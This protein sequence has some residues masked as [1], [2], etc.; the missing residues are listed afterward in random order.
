MM[1]ARLVQDATA[2][3]TIE[4]KNKLDQA[5][6]LVAVTSREKDRSTTE[7]KQTSYR[8]VIRKLL[9][10]D[11]LTS[12]IILFLASHAATERTDPRFSLLKSLNTT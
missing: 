12:P 7:G 9:N 6:P 10:I 5:Q 3:I 2:K 1:G 11:R 8:S 4:A